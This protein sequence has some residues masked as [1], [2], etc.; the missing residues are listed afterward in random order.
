[1]L[2]AARL[3]ELVGEFVCAEQLYLSVLVREPDN[4]RILFCYAQF[5]L[6]RGDNEMAERCVAFTAPAIGN[7]EKL[8]SFKKLF[9]IVF[10]EQDRNH[11]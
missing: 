7:F 5:F 8:Y 1:M 11:L 10:L 3:F 4:Y 6:K 9:I 2:E